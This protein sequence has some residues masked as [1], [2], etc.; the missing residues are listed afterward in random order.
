MKM[1]FKARVF[2]NVDFNDNYVS[3]DTDTFDGGVC[4]RS[5]TENIK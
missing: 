2:L 3:A 1:I 5:L 4:K